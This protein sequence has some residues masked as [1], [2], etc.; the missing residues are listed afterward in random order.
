MNSKKTQTYNWFYLKMGKQSSDLHQLDAPKPT[1]AIYFGRSRVKD[2]LKGKGD[3]KQAVQFCQCAEA[4]QREDTRMVV[5]AGDDVWILKPAGSVYEEEPIPRKGGIRKIMPVKILCRNQM[6]EVPPVLAGIR[7]NKF[8]GFGTFRPITNWGNIKALHSMLGIPIPLEHLD[9]SN[10]DACQLLE[11]LGSIEL[12][13]L[14]AKVFEAAGCFVPAY[15]GGTLIKAD[16]FAENKSAKAIELDGVVV[17]AKKTISIQVKGW[18][19]EHRSSEIHYM[20]RLPN[21]RLIGKGEISAEWL[22]QVLN[23]RRKDP[24]FEQVRFWL[25]FSLKRW[26]PKEFLKH[27]GMS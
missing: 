25:R 11:C 2:L 10:C 26:L 12:E 5:M 16:V 9:K 15:R 18:S 13:T 14:V 17:P 27:Y 20:F 6:I 19:D 24:A 3:D 21:R 22:L 8:L 7:S 4:D 1:A 23:S